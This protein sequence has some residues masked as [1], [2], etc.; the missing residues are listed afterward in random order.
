M[1]RGR[2]SRA[3]AYRRLGG[4]ILLATAL[5]GCSGDVTRRLPTPGAAPLN[6]AA[7]VPGTFIGSMTLTCPQPVR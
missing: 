7:C 6:N 3:R 5:A 2:D 4:V 1:G